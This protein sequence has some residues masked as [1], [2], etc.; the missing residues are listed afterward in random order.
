VAAILLFVGNGSSVLT[1]LIRQVNGVGMGPDR[2]LT[3]ALLLNVA[4]IIFGWRRYDE[5]SLEVRQRRHAEARALQMAET[6][7]LTGCL[8]RHSLAGA[9]EALI[10]GRQAGRDRRL[11]HDRPRSLQADQRPARP[12]G[13]RPAAGTM[14]RAHPCPAA[15]PWLAGAPWRR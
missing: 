5:L 7:A 1:Q 4:L 2:L 6:D 3:N 11:H 14:R 8:N 10:E 9:T 13:G 15:R 12:S